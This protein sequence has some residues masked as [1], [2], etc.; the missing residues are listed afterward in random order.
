MRKIDKQEIPKEV[1]SEFIKIGNALKKIKENNCIETIEEELYDRQKEFLNSDAHTKVMFGLNQGGKSRAGMF[2]IACHLMGR[3]PKWWKGIRATG[4]VDIWV[5]GETAN[6]VR[7]TLQEKLFGKLGQMGTGMLPRVVIDEPN[8]VRKPGI[9]GAI[10]RAGIKSDLGGLS[11]VQFFSFKQGREDFQ[12]STIWMVLFDEEPPEEIVN[13]CKPRVAVLKGYI[14]YTFTPLNGITPLYQ[15]LI[16]NPKVCKIW[17]TIDDVKHLIEKDLDE[18]YKGMSEYEIK[19]RK[20]GVA[21]TGTGKVFQ[22][23]E[24]EYSCEDFEISRH[25]RR[26]GGMDVGLSHPTAAVALAIDDASGCYYI[27]KEYCQGGSSPREHMRELSGWN[28]EFALDL[29]AFQRD[30]GGRESVAAMYQKEGLSIFKAANTAGSHEISAMKIRTLIGEGRLYIFKSCRKLLRQLDTYRTK[31]GADGRQKILKVNDDLVD[32]FSYAV[33]ASAQAST[34]GKRN[35]KQ[36]D[37]TVIEPHNASVYG[38]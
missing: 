5:V 24:D 21:T 34:T 28:V 19:A 31:E 9:P 15:D 11:T 13:E 20:Y 8:I 22:F 16:D 29:H 1:L 18:L 33:M 36:N 6:R 17:M 26:I 14:L 30:Q 27:Y 10:E 35:V 7:D 37:I 25:W 3:Y 23:Q 4:P 38:Y 12:G 32:A 2:E